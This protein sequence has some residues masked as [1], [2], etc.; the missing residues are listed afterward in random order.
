MC[1]SPFSI[2]DISVNS[3][4]FFVKQKFVAAAIEFDPDQY[5][6]MKVLFIEKYG[7]PTFVKHW[8]I[9]DPAGTPV[10]NESLQWRFSKTLVVLMRHSNQFHMGL[11]SL[12]LSW[13][14]DK[15]TNEKPPKDSF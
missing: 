5:E 2:G 12:G 1:E 9:S 8:L 10:E 7:K 15:V 11:G 13:W 3:D 6:T 14:F 4:L